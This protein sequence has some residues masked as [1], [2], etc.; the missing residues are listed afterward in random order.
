[1]PS[2]EEESLWLVGREAGGAGGHQQQ[3]QQPQQAAQHHQQ[4]H[5]HQG[6]ASRPSGQLYTEEM[7]TV[8]AGGGTTVGPSSGRRADPAE[9][10]LIDSAADAALLDQF[11]EDAIKQ[12]GFG[13]GRTAKVV[14]ASREQLRAFFLSQVYRR[15]CGLVKWD[16]R[17]LFVLICVFKSA[18]ELAF[19]R[20]EFR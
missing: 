11:H 16:P 9:R 6:P 13:F 10:D 7:Q 5:R 18:V 2:S 20:N 8:A 17:A 15:L 14:G 12:V 4:Q 1:M 3:Q 19:E